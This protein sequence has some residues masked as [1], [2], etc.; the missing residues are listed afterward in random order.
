MNTH[1]LCISII[2][3]FKIRYISS[4]VPH[5]IITIVYKTRPTRPRS[6]AARGTK[7][8]DNWL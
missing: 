1:L 2:M 8:D 5:M 4:Q 7:I 6:H 3:S